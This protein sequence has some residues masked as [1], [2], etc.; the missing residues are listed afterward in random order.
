MA[1]LAARPR[2]HDPSGANLCPPSCTIERMPLP[3]YIRIASAKDS[4]RVG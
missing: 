4:P 2:Q 3:I 1:M